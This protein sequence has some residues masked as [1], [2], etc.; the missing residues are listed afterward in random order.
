MIEKGLIY[1]IRAEH[2]QIKHKKID[3]PIEK[4]VKAMNR[5]FT[6]EEF[7]IADKQ[8]MFYLTSNQETANERKIAFHTNQTSGKSE[9]VNCGETGM[10][11]LN[12]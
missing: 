3:G 9:N 8:I 12:Y 11:T 2:L 4:G 5:K 1:R 10:H 6:K 7:W